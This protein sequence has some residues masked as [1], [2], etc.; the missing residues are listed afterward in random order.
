MTA[1]TEPSSVAIHSD[2][3]GTW[4]GVTSTTSTIGEGA[5]GASVS[6]VLSLHPAA[7]IRAAT[8]PI[9]AGNQARNVSI[10]RLLCPRPTV[11]GHTNAVAHG[12]TLGTF[13]AGTEHRRLWGWGP[14]P[15]LV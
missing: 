5:A 1:L 4:R 15:T 10:D 9:A 13:P 12:R 11:A 7:R 8:L 3:I 2:W 6:A 14:S